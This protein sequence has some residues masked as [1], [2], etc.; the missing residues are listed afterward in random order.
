MAQQPMMIGTISSTNVPMP[1]IAL[2][3]IR[4][5]ALHLDSMDTFSTEKTDKTWN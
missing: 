2:P 5:A 1:S 4:T 3:T